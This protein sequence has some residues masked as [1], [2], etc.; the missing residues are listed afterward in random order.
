MHD[1]EKALSSA[2]KYI[3]QRKAKKKMK[4]INKNDQISCHDIDN[5]LKADKLVQTIQKLSPQSFKRMKE[6]KYTKMNSL[7]AKHSNYIST[8][9]NKERIIALD[10]SDIWQSVYQ[11]NYSIIMFLFL[12]SDIFTYKF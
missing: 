3:E 8:Y 10:L 9:R 4:V 5:A 7:K 12:F 1:Q 6:H 2:T 11:K